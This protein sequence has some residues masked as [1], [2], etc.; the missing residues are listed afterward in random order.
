V[1]VTPMDA[2]LLQLVA[3]ARSGARPGTR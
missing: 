2:E 3:D 1:D